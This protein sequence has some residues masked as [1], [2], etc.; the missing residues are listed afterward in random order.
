MPDGV[1]EAVDLEIA[2][3][4]RAEIGDKL[5]NRHGL[6]G[7]VGAIVPEHEMPYLPDGTP[8]DAVLNPLSIP[9]RMTLG[10]F[11]LSRGDKT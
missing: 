10:G 3:W 4:R 8:V 2:Q 7:V 9:S 11:C 1:D 6:K 5:T